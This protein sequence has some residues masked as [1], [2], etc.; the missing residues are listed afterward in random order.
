MKCKIKF[1]EVL[2]K[3]N[4]FF[5]KLD[6]FNFVVK[7]ASHTNSIISFKWERV[8]IEKRD[9]LNYVELTLYLK[10]F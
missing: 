2:I 5:V 8:I 6:I 1:F 7:E 3:K 4:S 9:C 10:Y